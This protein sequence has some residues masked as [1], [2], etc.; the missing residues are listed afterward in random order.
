MSRISVIIPTHNYGKYICDA[1]ESVVNQTYK[2][3]EIIVVDDGS[4]DN[5]SKLLNNY[6]Q[7]IDYYFIQN[8]GPA[9]ARNYGINKAKGEYICFLD[10]D[11]VFYPEKLQSQIEIIK[12]DKS[13]GLVHS[14]FLYVK[15]NLSSV[16]YHYKCRKTSSHNEAL[17]YLWYHNY[18]NTSTVM[19]VK[20]YLFQVG[21]FNEK[22]RYGEDYDL[23]LRL[24]KYYKFHCI[25]K[26]LVKTRSH[27]MNQC[28]KI[29]TIERLKSTKEI[30]NSLKEYFKSE[31]PYN[32]HIK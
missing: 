2:A 3:Y 27:S 10:A 28:K 18:I 9:G 29:D 32:I 11:D 4:T 26:P 14:D 15:N 30:R 6:S 12:M 23:W 24:G 22:Y 7:Y 31:G 17:Q 19:V 20:E 21:L 8:K 1:I 16:Y 5:T 25:H 13:I